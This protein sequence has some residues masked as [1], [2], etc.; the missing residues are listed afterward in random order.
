MKIIIDSLKTQS[1]KALDLVSQGKRL[2]TTS[3]GKM[4][5]LLSNENSK[6]YEKEQYDEKHYFLIPYKLHS[7]FD[8]LSTRWCSTDK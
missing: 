1:S 2:I 4:P 3:L 5:F 8:A 7:L 6:L